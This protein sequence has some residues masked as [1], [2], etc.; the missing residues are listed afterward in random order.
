MA[1]FCKAEFEALARLVRDLGDCAENMRSAMRQLEDIGPR[2]AGSTELEDAC[3]DFQDKWGHGIKLIAEATGGVAEKV[4][5]SGRLFQHLE[6]EVA[7]K[8]R[9]VKVGA[10]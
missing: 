5:Q 9:S 2:G 8:V 3:D 4:A 10:R 6:D 1:S 7:A